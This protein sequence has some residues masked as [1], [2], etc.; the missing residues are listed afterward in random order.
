[1]QAHLGTALGVAGAAAQQ[2]LDGDQHDGDPD[3]QDG[4][5]GGGVAVA[6]A[7]PHPQHTVGDRR[8]VE[9]PDGA[10][11]GEHLHPDQRS[12]GGE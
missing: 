2:S 5:F 3:Q 10:D 7:E 11:I 8:H 6:G 4:E 9:Q 12:A 1:M